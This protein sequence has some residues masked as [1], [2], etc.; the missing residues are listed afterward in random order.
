MAK[1]TKYIYAGSSASSG[2]TFNNPRSLGLTLATGERPKGAV[3]ISGGAWY[4]GYGNTGTT[5]TYNVYLCD[6]AGNN[7]ALI[8]T[9]SIKGQQT[10]NV[11]SLSASVDQASLKAK[12]LYIKIT[13][14]NADQL[15]FMNTMTIIVNTVSDAPAYTKVVSGNK[16]KATDRSQTGTPTTQGAKIQDSHFSAGTKA[17]A[18]TFNEKVL[19]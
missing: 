7:G 8:G 15:K 9:I 2:Y 1:Y 10:I 12:A 11:V 19:S 17:E 5:Y 14:S 18:S 3:S 4:L 6:S 16:I 13:G